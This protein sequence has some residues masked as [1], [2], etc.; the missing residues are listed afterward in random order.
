MSQLQNELCPR[1][2]ASKLSERRPPTWIAR[3]GNENSQN[4]AFF[5]ILS[6]SRNF[7]VASYI[8]GGTMWKL[9][10]W[11][12]RKCGTFWCLELLK[13][14]YRRSESDDSEIFDLS[15]KIS[16][17]Q[18]K[19]H[20]HN[21]DLRVSPLNQAHT[22]PICPTLIQWWSLQIKIVAVGFF[23]DTDL[24]TGFMHTYKGAGS[25]HDIRKSMK[26]LCANDT[27]RYPKVLKIRPNHGCQQILMWE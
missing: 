13:R 1:S 18:K 14:S 15:P 21:F 23:L 16:G 5:C 17:V 11:G 12:F 9:T 20:G 19:S 4:F 8:R 24:P 10:S 7:Y 25:F 6:I 2:V 22:I 26:K 3:G 27:S